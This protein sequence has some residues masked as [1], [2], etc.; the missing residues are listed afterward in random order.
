MGYNPTIEEIKD[1]VEQVRKLGKTA[2]Y[3]KE[4]DNA[5]MISIDTVIKHDTNHY[6][7]QKSD[8]DYRQGEAI[9][10]YS[11]HSENVLII[12]GHFNL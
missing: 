5:I 1:M 7:G 12:T 8:F 2:L 4:H 6:N 3:Q 9:E 10:I 11:K